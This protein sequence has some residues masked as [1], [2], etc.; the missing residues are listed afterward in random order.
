[1][2]KS[3]RP[4]HKINYLRDFEILFEGNW[5]RIGT[6]LENFYPD[7]VIEEPMRSSMN[8]TAISVS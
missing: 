5:N 8:W 1:M 2:F 4:D 3:C 7:A 6:A